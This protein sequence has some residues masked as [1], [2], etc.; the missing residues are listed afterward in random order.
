MLGDTRV[1]CNPRG[2]DTYNGT[3]FT[4]WDVNKVIEI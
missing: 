1:V 4:G 3:E 2:Y